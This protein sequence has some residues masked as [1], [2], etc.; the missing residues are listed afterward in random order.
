LWCH[1]FRCLSF[2]KKAANGA[3][4]AMSQGAALT[5]APRAL[6]L[7]AEVVGRENVV[8]GT[9]CRLGG[10]LHPQ[11]AWAKLRDGAAQHTSVYDLPELFLTSRATHHRVGK[12]RLDR[13]FAP[14]IK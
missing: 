13:C 9:R 2:R 6:T 7:F 10:R 8:A 1:N 11:I 3:T 12:K 4:I 14:R 5:L